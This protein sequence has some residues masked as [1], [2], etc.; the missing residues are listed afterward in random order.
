MAKRYAISDEAWGVVADLFIELMV[1]G[2]RA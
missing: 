1:E 2:D